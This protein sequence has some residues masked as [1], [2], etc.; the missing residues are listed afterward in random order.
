[1]FGAHDMQAVRFQLSLAIE[2]ASGVFVHVPGGGGIQ[3]V[4]HFADLIRATS[5][6]GT[7][8]LTAVVD[9]ADIVEGAQFIFG[10]P[11]GSGAEGA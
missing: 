8:I 6:P 3:A 9:V 11:D 10:R 4:K 5:I 2:T 1:M 7:L